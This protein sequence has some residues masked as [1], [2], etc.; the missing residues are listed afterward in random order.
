MSYGPGPR[1][2]RSIWLAMI[3]TVLL[4][5]PACAQSDVPGPGAATA[6]SAGSPLRSNSVSAVDMKSLPETIGIEHQDRINRFNR[7]AREVGVV[8]PQVDDMQLGAGQVPGF[9]YPVPVVRLRFEERAFFDF[10]LDTTRADSEAVLD[11][12][13]NNMRRDV[14]DVQLTILGHTDAVGSDA[15]NKNLS[16]RRAASV[17]QALIKRGVNPRQLSTVAVGEAQPIAPNSTDLGRARNRRVE[18][19]ISASEAANLILISK[20]RV[21]SEF[22]VLSPSIKPAT[23]AAAEL[24][25]FKPIVPA[26]AGPLQLAPSGTVQGKRP[27]PAAQAAKLAPI[28]NPKLM[29]LKQFQQAQ[30]NQEFEL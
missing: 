8:P 6:T 21:I 26:R 10:N 13:A 5:G 3:C 20:R 27:M 23:T 15:Y 4:N 11:L 14:P 7:L 22:L 9:D 17:M 2:Y 24:R 30:L 19:M 16:Q 12:M 28:P 1:R 29:P 18:F 25:V